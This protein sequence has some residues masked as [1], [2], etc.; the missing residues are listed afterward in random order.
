MGTGMYMSPEQWKTTSVDIRADIYSLGCTLYHLLDG[1]PPFHDSDLKPEKAHEK[2]PVPP[3]DG[4]A[5]AK[6]DLWDIIKKML[7]KRPE[8]RFQSPA[9]VA[10]ASRRFAAGMTSRR[11][12]SAMRRRA[13]P[14]ARPLELRSRTARPLR[15]RRELVHPDVR[16]PRA[17]RRTSRRSSPRASS[18]SRSPVGILGCGA[19]RLFVTVSVR[20]R[21]RRP[22][23]R[24]RE[25]RA[26]GGLTKRRGSFRRN[27]PGSFT[28]CANRNTRNSTPSPATPTW[29]RFTQPSAS[30]SLPRRLFARKRPSAGAVHESTLREVSRDARQPRSDRPRWSRNDARAARRVAGASRRRANAGRVAPDRRA[31]RSAARAGRGE[32]RRCFEAQAGYGVFLEGEAAPVARGLLALCLSDRATIAAT[33]SEE[34]ELIQQAM[35]VLK[36]GAAPCFEGYIMG[37]QSLAQ[38]E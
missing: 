29:K 6:R 16:R 21:R 7:A 33:P 3:I 28:Q 2:S 5:E 1:R 36:T 20:I 14:L 12:R 32:C 15:R 13:K 18:R 22:L 38:A 37:S 8:D 30:R 35:D 24:C 27:A 23:G 26:C 4:D 25:C 17:P 11:S 10:T 19:I 9:E 31:A 34:D